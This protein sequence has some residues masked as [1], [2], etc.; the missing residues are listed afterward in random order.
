[1]PEREHPRADHPGERI[2]ENAA[3]VHEPLGEEAVQ[4]IHEDGVH[5][6]HHEKETPLRLLAEIDDP[7]ESQEQQG[8][9]SA[10]HERIGWGEHPLDD[11]NERVER[12]PR[13]NADSPA[14]RE[15]ADETAVVVLREQRPDDAAI[16]HDRDRGEGGIEVSPA[17]GAADKCIVEEK[18]Q[19]L[20]EDVAVT[21][22]IIH[23]DDEDEQPVD[24]EESGERPEPYGNALADKQE[25]EEIADRQHLEHSGA[26][27]RPMHPDP[28]QEEP[29]A[30]EQRG[31]SGCMTQPYAVGFPPSP[32][33]RLGEPHGHSDDEEERRENEVLEM[34]PHPIGVGKLRVEEFRDGIVHHLLQPQSPHEHG[35][36]NKS[37]ERIERRHPATGVEHGSRFGHDSPAL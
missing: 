34:E 20:E 8:S 31:P 37:P 22:H 36:H 7:V 5:P 27:I 3:G 26:E 11:G 4:D 16:D 2:E 9:D 33:L 30:E 12:Q 13:E 18:D 10:G 1:M 15:G 29:E 14:D 23:G 21:A 25:T 24:E 35:E 19:I 32:P 6:E 17:G 28:T